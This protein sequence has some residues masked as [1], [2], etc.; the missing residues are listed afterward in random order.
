MS[1]D[2]NSSIGQSN[3]IHAA[4]S[5]FYSDI[6]AAITSG[7]EFPKISDIASELDYSELHRL[8]VEMQSQ[9]ISFG[10]GAAV[11]TTHLA[12]AVLREYGMRVK[13]KSEY[14]IDGVVDSKT[15]SD[16]YTS[17]GVIKSNML[18]GNTSNG[19]LT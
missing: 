4:L 11:E 10:E 1:I 3:T 17:S 19:S 9:A 18:Q 8:A 2:P 16:Y 7:G 12:L 15:E 13:S 6:A 5:K 14:Y